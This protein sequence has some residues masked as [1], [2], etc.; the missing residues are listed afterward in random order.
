MAQSGMYVS[1][2]KFIYEPY[3]HIFTRIFGSDN[4]YKGLSSFTVEMIELRNILKR[5]NKYSTVDGLSLCEADEN[6]TFDNAVKY[7]D[8]DR[9]QEVRSLVEAKIKNAE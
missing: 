2:E 7:L 8:N 5:S 1:S 9:N 3:H 4:I 6:P